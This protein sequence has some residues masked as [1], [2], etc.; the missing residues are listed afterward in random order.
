MRTQAVN[1]AYGGQIWSLVGSGALARNIAAV[2]GGNETVWYTTLITSFTGFL[3]PCVSEAADYWGR[4]WLLVSLTAL[5]C[6]GS[7][8]VSRAS[9]SPGILAGFAIIGLAFGAQ[10]LVIAVSS[11][12]LPRRQRTYG[13]A[14]SGIV[15]CSSGVLALVVGGVLTRH[16]NDEGFRVYFYI[17]AGFFALAALICGVL[18]NPPPRELQLKLQFHEKLRKLDWPAYALLIIGVVLFCIGLSWSQNPYPWSNAHVSAPFAIGL[19][20][21]IV[22]ALYAR[23]IKKDGMLHHS[24]FKHRNFSIACGCLFVEGLSFFSANSYLPL[25]AAL[26]FTTDPVMVGLHFAIAFIAAMVTLLFSA[27]Y[28]WKTRTIRPP[29]IAAFLCFVI[30]FVLMATINTNTPVSNFWGYPVFIGAGFGTAIATL[31]TVAQFATPP[32]LI[33]TTTGVLLTFRTIGGT[34]GLAVFNAVFHHG[35]AEN[36][37]PKI[38]AATLPLGLPKTSLGPLIGAL[39]TSDFPALAKIPG[40]TEEIEA[41]AVHALDESYIIALRYVWITGG[42]FVLI[43]LVGKFEAFRRS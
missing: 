16:D 25:E 29:T 23:Y 3:A 35:M 14:A 34:V 17:S 42:A 27:T 24:L 32:E 11:E 21:L 43:A 37:A 5:G 20:F 10:P 9:A 19:V 41:A 4:K 1:L 15:G 8:V 7:I 13:Q 18:Y 33:S 12:I 22:L 36:L 28:S 26:L 2:T 40:L 39:A 30:F 6:V 38:S 31:T